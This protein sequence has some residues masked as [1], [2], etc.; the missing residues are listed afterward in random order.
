MMANL[1]HLDVQNIRHLVGG[2]ETTKAKMDFYASQATDTKIK[3]FFQ[4]GAN[5]ATKSKQQ[6]LEFLN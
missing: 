5:S 6:L 2:F 1:S 3:Q 4:D